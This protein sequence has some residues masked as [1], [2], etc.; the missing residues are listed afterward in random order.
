MLFERSICVFMEHLN[1]TELNRWV[2]ERMALLAP[3]ADCEPDLDAARVRWADRFSAQPSARRQPWLVWATVVALACTTV[4]LT[5]PTTRVLAQ[6]LWQKLTLGGIEVVQVNLKNLSEQVPSLILQRLDQPVPPLPASQASEAA[7]R[8][9]FTPR[10]PHPGVLSTS[11]QLSTLPA[12]SFG[13]V[14]RTAD[15]ELTLRQAGVADQVVSP[16]W[17]GAHITLQTSPIVTATWPDIT[18]MQGLPP[19][20]STP[21]GFDLSAFVTA[22]L[23]AIGMDRENAYRLGQRTTTTP[24]LLLGISREEHITMR[25]VTL[26]AGPATLVEDLDEHGQT[27][28]IT[29]LWSV[30]D[31]IYIL[32]GAI[33]A[34]L[35]ITIANAVE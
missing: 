11:A 20:I 7:Q 25:E 16:R 33:T 12:M 5:Y 24:A 27:E 30:P 32:S 35:A 6:Q 17:D 8:V 10:L 26:G 4:L 18:L 29:L 13:T 28:R 1:N 21:S 3:P 31:R 15:L 22:L 14:L 34:D 23:R 9:G 19:V 2:E